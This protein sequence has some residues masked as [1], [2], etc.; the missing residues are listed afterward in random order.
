MNS[1]STIVAAFLLLLAPA[2]AHAFTPLV[3][4]PGVSD[5]ESV[6]FQTYIN[7]LYAL[8]ISIAGLLSVIKIIIAGVKWMLSDVVTSKQEA[9]GEIQGALLGLLIVVSAVLI[10]NQINPQLTTTNLITTTVDR[11]SGN[12]TANLNQGSPLPSGSVVSSG[13][14]TTQYDA[15]G[16]VIGCF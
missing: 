12:P 11:V 16:N 3:G 14:C 9:K 6:G 1:K 15:S 13:P 4:I 8:S 5:P 2:L 10:L 7:T